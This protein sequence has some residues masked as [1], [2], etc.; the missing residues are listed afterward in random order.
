[1]EM[2]DKIITS[3][4]AEEFLKVKYGSYRG[5]V[6]SKYQDGY[7]GYFEEANQEVIEKTGKSIL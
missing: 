2:S 3:E 7:L 1:M 6:A 4:L 5:Y